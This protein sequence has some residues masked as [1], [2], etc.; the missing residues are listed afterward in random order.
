MATLGQI[1]PVPLGGIVSVPDAGGGAG[2]AVVTSQVINAMWQNA[3]AKAQAGVDV[4]RG[5]MALADPAPK[6]DVNGVY[7]TAPD[8][9]APPR[10]D[11]PDPDAGK[12]LYESQLRHMKDLIT[13]GFAK[14]IGDYFPRTDWFDAAIDWCHKAIRDGG[15]GINA[16]V[17]AQLWER[18]RARIRRK[19]GADRD[20]AM[21][22]W[23][24]KGFPQPPGA[25]AMQIR[26]I[27]QTASDELSAQSRDI[28]IKSFET[29][30]E[31]VRFAVKELLD[32]RMKALDAAL[33]YIRTL[34]LGPET[35]MK[36]ATGL[37]GLQY[38]LMRALTAMYT[39]QVSALSPQIQLLIAD[40]ELRQKS[41][42]ANLDSDLAVIEAKV[43]AAL[44]AAQMLGTQ[45]A[46][47]INAI[48]ARASI[49]GNDSS[50]LNP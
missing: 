29:E 20:K 12:K 40:A 35:A 15:T 25:L 13:D 28:A 26:L 22:E 43:R 32:L 47:G 11:A 39:A 17:E 46:A 4:T 42:K 48:G 24:A 16:N 6:M 36:L 31:N 1:N 10:L 30:V 2:A 38:E 19:A 49:S 7:G 45:A 33:N 3:Q 50:Q 8:V 21:K 27:D 9:P 44:A 5:A 23:A 41:A 37:S 18:D 14:F 34:M